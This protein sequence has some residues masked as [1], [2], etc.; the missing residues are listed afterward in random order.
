[1]RDRQKGLSWRELEVEALIIQQA[2]VREKPEIVETLCVKIKELEVTI[3]RLTEDIGE[4]RRTVAELEA[5]R[6][7]A[8][9]MRQEAPEKSTQT[10]E[11]AQEA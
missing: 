10:S 7:E 3:A 1:M 2:R 11:D 9:R 8:T 5:A 4:L 6:I